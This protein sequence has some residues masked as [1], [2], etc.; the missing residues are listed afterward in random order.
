MDYEEKINDLKREIESLQ[1]EKTRVMR[2]WVNAECPVKIGDKIAV[3][4]YSHA[5]KIMEVD[6]IYVKDL[7]SRGYCFLAKGRIV[8]KDG[9][10]GTQTGEWHSNR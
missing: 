2:E 8:K 6:S 9:T 5:G 1:D 3:N 7:Y 4:G 10:C